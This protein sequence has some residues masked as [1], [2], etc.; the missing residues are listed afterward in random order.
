ME[1]NPSQSAQTRRCW[2]TPLFYFTWRS[3]KVLSLSPPQRSDF[4]DLLFHSEYENAIWINEFGLCLL[5]ASMPAF[6]YIPRKSIRCGRLKYFCVYCGCFQL[7][8]IIGCWYFSLVFRAFAF[9]LIKLFHNT[10]LCLGVRWSTEKLMRKL[11]DGF[12]ACLSSCDLWGQSLVW[13]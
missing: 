3:T 1:Q 7:H 2:K 6:I 10:L 13:S 9:S 5:I 8:D 12:F 4:D 11:W